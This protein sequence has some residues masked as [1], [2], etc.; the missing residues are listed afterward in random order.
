MT[1]QP[2][3]WLKAVLE[4]S[5]LLF[6]FLLFHFI[7]AG[8]PFLSSS[9]AN[10]TSPSSLEI[11]QIALKAPSSELTVVERAQSKFISESSK[12]KLNSASSAE[13]EMILKQNW[14]VLVPKF[15]GTIR[16]AFHIVQQIQRA[17]WGSIVFGSWVDVISNRP[18]RL[19]KTRSRNTTSATLKGHRKSRIQPNSIFFSAQ[20]LRIT[21][22]LVLGR[23][24]SWGLGAL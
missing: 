23:K 13:K 7:S 17:D 6:V 11:L 8:F 9:S 10:K 3:S 20:V 18:L 2:S 24:K 5:F 15:I 12:S 21:N 19:P 16:F 22:G 1:K 14:H 4:F